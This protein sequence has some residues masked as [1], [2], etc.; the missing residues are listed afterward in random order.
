MIAYSHKHRFLI[1]LLCLFCVRGMAVPSL[2]V[3]AQKYTA[4]P[5]AFFPVNY[6]VLWEGSPGAYTVLPP[7]L[8][9][10]DWGEAALLEIKSKKDGDTNETCIVVGF[11]ATEAGVYETPPID[12]RVVEWMEGHA[13]GITAVPPE[14]TAQVLSA[15]P[16]TVTIQSSRTLLFGAIGTLVLLLLSGAVI[17]LLLRRRARI[18]RAV[19][20][21]GFEEQGQSL[22]H[23]ARRH[24]LD[25]DYYAFYRT[26][27]RAC[28]LAARV[29]GNQDERLFTRLDDRIKDTGYRG[30]RPSED[31]LEGDFKDVEHWIVRASRRP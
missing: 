7:T 29:S 4:Q 13:S 23:E 18:H 15:A 21:P 12:L 24:R 6:K 28:D 17:F 8:P 1:P 31:D 11:R 16:V 9:A 30:Q 14:T 10:L 20:G 5:G 3:S 22:L 19:E 27:R 2:E 25:G 26:L